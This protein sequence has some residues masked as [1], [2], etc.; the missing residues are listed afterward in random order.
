MWW[1]LGIRKKNKEIRMFRQAS[2]M[3]DCPLG[4][5]KK[6]LPDK[7]TAFSYVQ[8]GLAGLFPAAA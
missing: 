3:K 5:T 7:P 8:H 1:F 4:K 6:T 2:G